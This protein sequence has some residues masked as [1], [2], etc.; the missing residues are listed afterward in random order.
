[1]F[2]SL[3]FFVAAW[4]TSSFARAQNAPRY[5]IPD[6]VNC[7]SC[8]ISARRILAIETSS[9]RQWGDRI[10]AAIRTDSRGRFW[11]MG[12]DA[13]RVY[14]AAGLLIRD[15]S[16]WGGVK[17]VNA[18][19]AISLP[20]DSILVLDAAQEKA[21]I[22]DDQLNAVRSIAL[23]IPANTGMIL[24]W[25]TRVILNGLVPTTDAAGFPLHE[26]SFSGSVSAL[27]S[28]FG[29]DSTG[30]LRISAEANMLQSLSID[31]DGNF[32]SA[33]LGTYRLGHWSARPRLIKTIIRDADWFPGSESPRLGG[34]T[35]PPSPLVVA[36]QS[37]TGGLV[38]VFS[39]IPSSKWQSAWPPV[40]PG[41][42]EVAITSRTVSTLYNSVV[43]V[44]DT[45]R[46][47]VLSRVSIPE[48]VI[49]VLPNQ[50][51]VFL[52]SDV[53]LPSLIVI[54][55]EAKIKK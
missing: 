45:R 17:F 5:H 43:E 7:N 36:I 11:V 39:R 12:Q 28:S 8:A 34:P 19:D 54:Q 42:V 23:G 49:S 44:L 26:T 13:P 52:S 25:P 37:D 10:P 4:S 3:V 40:S 22:F 24:Q 38:W 1:M 29:S 55:F 15:E 48:V 18:S 53:K 33:E 47:R 20:G 2:R 21:T 51:A 6:D 32:W 50:R 27:V 31:S 30:K 9:E 14:N 41:L 46:R 16:S 35:K